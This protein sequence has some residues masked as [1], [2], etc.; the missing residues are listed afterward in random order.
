MKVVK[1]SG[2]LSIPSSGGA[3]VFYQKEIIGRGGFEKRKI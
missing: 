1:F 2:R 3:A